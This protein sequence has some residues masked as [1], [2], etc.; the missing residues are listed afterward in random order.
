MNILVTGASGFVGQHLLSH[1][2]ES[3]NNHV[4]T[5]GRSKVNCSDKHFFGDLSDSADFSPVLNGIDVIIHC[6]GRAHIINDNVKDP[7]DVYREVNTRATVNLARSA[8]KSGVKRFIYLSSI[9]VNGE[10]TSVH[11]PFLS[12]D[13]HS[14]IDDYG[15]SKSE[16]EFGLINAAKNT[17]LDYVI[18]R[19]P[20]IY[21]EGV[22]ANFES[23]MNLVDKGIPL[24]FGC[25]NNNLRS[26]VSI[27][28]LIDLLDVCISHPKAAN[29]IF[30]VSDDH[31]ISTSDLV[32]KM[33]QALGKKVFQIPIPIFLYKL[34]GKISNRQGVIDRLINSL[35]VDINH[36]K[37]TL[38]WTAP[39]SLD[40][41]FKEVAEYIKNNKA[42]EKK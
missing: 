9:K 1:L 7:L 30:L 38:N 35:H 39:Q 19:P 26:L 40:V 25:I 22:K 14:P 4:V 27:G 41:G 23:L 36:T 31:D 37:N 42:N 29:E 32:E 2:K 34:L 21:G 10:S 28:N 13:S 3:T 17:G 33:S 12:S 18:I 24:P 16:A 8:V 5:Y 11:N 20:L 15:I 6:A